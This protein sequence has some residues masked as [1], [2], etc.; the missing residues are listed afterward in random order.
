M[1]ISQRDKLF[2]GVGAFG[3]GSVNQMLGN[4][5]M[6]FGTGVLGLSGTLMGLAIA[7][8]TVW[9]A[10]T[11]PIV[12]ALSDNYRGKFGK[13]HIFMLVGCCAVALINLLIWNIVPAWG[14]MRKFFLLLFALL[15]IET[16]NTVYSTPYSALGFDMCQTYHERTKI[17]SY[18]TVF[19]SAALLVPSLLMGIALN[20]KAVATMD[21]ASSGYQVI[22]IITST[23]CLLTGFVTIFGTW[24][25]RNNGT[26][27]TKLTVGKPKVS[28]LAAFFAVLDD[29]NNVFLITAYAIA[30]SCSA[31]LTSL[32]M[33]VFTYTFHFSSWQISFVMTCLVAG[34]I[35][36]Q[37]LW[38]AVSS[39]VGKKRTVQTALWVVLLGVAGFAILLTVRIFLP[40]TLVLWLLAVNILVIS[41][42]VGCIYSLPISMFADNVKMDSTAMATGFL[43]FCTKCTNAFVT[44][45]VGFL[46]DMVGFQS[47]LATQ[48][49]QV[50]TSLG[51]LLVGGVTVAGIVASFLFGKYQDKADETVVS[52]H[53]EQK[54]IRQV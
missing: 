29:R 7:I 17:Q 31:F 45:L 53:N 33:H 18:K 34:V 49:L 50:S 3:Y 12:G 19:Q 22:A 26:I 46:L 30:L 54:H 39:R 10:V 14:E 32:G 37:P 48:S 27:P 20:P 43:T 38:C 21:T 42:G 2:Y 11:D 36:G 16:F 13:R 8:S 25:Y 35:A 40:V 28:V 44:F 47:G 4:Y 52:Y 24:R 15:L 9:D 6:F 1:K 5:L 41:M 51:W 23:L